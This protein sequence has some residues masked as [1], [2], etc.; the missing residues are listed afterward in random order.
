MVDQLKEMIPVL[1]K[2]SGK[3]VQ[4]RKFQPGDSS[5]KDASLAGGGF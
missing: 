3:N 5:G 2:V 1:E 4:G